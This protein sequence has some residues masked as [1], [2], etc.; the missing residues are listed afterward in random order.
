MNVEFNHSTFL[1]SQKR[2]ESRILEN[3]H[4]TLIG[5]WTFT[6][7]YSFCRQHNNKKSHAMPQEKK[8]TFQPFYSRENS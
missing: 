3:G 2:F 6:V 5:A 7:H 1:F 4:S 8:N